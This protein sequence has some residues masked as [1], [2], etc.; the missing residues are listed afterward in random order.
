MTE[1]PQEFLPLY[2]Q[3]AAEHMAAHGNKK[4][5]FVLMIPNR[6]PTECIWL[7]PCYGFFVVKNKENSGFLTIKELPEGSM[8]LNQHYETEEDEP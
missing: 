4:I 8:I 6:V 3:K 7:E 1:I 2:A 5:Y